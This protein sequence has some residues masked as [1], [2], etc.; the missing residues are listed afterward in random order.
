M[1][2]S[3]MFICLLCTLFVFSSGRKYDKLVFSIQLSIQTYKEITTPLLVRPFLLSLPYLQSIKSDN[4]PTNFQ[5]FTNPYDALLHSPSGKFIHSSD[6]LALPF[7]A[8]V[9]RV[10][11]L[12]ILICHPIYATPIPY[13]IQ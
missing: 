11:T 12:L 6:I 5:I 8:T 10:H 13:T 1:V 9:W 7:K 2:C 4:S 3:D